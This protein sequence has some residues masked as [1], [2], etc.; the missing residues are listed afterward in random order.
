MKSYSD[1]LPNV[2]KEEINRA[3][4]VA[5]EAVDVSKGTLQTSIETLH[6]TNRTLRTEKLNTKLLITNIII[7]T[8]NALGWAYLIFY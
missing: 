6:A 8:T 1:E 3:A 2:T 7:G 4:D 5:Q